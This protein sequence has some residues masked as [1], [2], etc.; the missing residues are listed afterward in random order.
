MSEDQLMDTISPQ[1]ALK[2]IKEHEDDSNFE[3]LDIRS[4]REFESGHIPKAKS[5]HYEG[6][7]FKKKVD[8]LDKEKEYVIYCKSGVRGGYFLNQMKESGFKKA[9]NIQGGFLGWKIS[10][11]PLTN[12]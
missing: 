9:H 3:I 6:H 1:D 5:L 7:E 8:N 11:L 4:D 2:L 12:E 10:K